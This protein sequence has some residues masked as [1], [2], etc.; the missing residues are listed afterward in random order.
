MT[1]RQSVRLVVALLLTIL[2]GQSLA[3]TPDATPLAVVKNTTDRILALSTQA[4][5]YYKENPQRYYD[6]VSDVL[7]PVV[8]FDGFAR[9]VMAT[10]ASARLYQSLK[11]EQEKQQFQQR[12]SRF[13]S[14]LRETVITT[15]ADSLLAFNGER[16]SVSVPPGG[17]AKNH[18]ATVLQEIYSSSGKVYQVFYS[19]REFRDGGWKVRNVTVDGVNFGQLYRTQFAN[20]VEKARGDVDQAIENWGNANA[21]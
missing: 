4:R 2:A 6:Q 13:A 20:G 10:Y 7:L 3:A 17:E 19:M 5:S 16:I 1:Y 9:G 14:K 21:G 15:Y 8:D 18:R 12:I 11:T